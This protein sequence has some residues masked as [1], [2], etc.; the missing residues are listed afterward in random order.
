MGYTFKFL[1]KLMHPLPPF[2][3]PLTGTLI[4]REC[5][6]QF[7]DVCPGRLAGGW[8]LTIHTQ[9]V[10]EWPENFTLFCTTWKQK[11]R[12]KSPKVPTL[13][14]L[15]VQVQ[16]QITIEFDQLSATLLLKRTVNLSLIKLTTTYGQ[17]RTRHLLLCPSLLVQNATQFHN[18]H[19]T[20]S[21]PTSSFAPLNPLPI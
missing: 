7:W 11:G 3:R 15:S 14:F 1:V 20:L 18:S 9:S 2:I 10:Y 8:L 4:V 19:G 17:G 21:S 6:H 13:P 16:F 5:T 12:R